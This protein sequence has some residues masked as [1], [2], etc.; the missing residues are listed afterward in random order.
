VQIDPLGQFL[1]VPEQGT[2]QIDVYH[3][4]SDGSL[5]GS[6]TF[7][8]VGATPFGMA[9]NL[10]SSRQEF[11]VA[12]AEGAPDGTGAVTAYRLENGDLRLI[13][14]PVPDHQMDPCWMVITPDGH[15]AYTSNAHSQSISGY[16]IL[17]DGTLSLLNPNG[18]SGTTPSDTLPIEEA[19]SSDGRFLYVLD[20]RALLTPPG[21]ATLS[22]FLIEHDGS[23][24][25]ILDSAQ[26]ILPWSAIGLAA[27]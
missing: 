9:F 16:R 1:L 21:P 23:L 19:L 3:I 20:S 6:T 26:I 25:S 2:D 27:D 8:S 11:I 24:T 4:Q 12:D 13:H 14:G 18:I 10:A 15:F 17:E 5:S 7:P 22:G